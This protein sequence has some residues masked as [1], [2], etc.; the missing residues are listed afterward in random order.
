MELNDVEKYSAR[1][2]QES[3]LQSNIQVKLKGRALTL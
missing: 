3:K 1:E 2:Y